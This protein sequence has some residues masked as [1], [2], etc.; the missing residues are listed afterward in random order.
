[1][2]QS[3]LGVAVV[4]TSVLSL[5]MLP[6][7]FARTY[8][9]MGSPLMDRRSTLTGFNPPALLEGDEATRADQD[10]AARAAWAGVQNTKYDAP[11]TVRIEGTDE[12]VIKRIQLA[13]RVS[14]VLVL[15][16]LGT[17]VLVVQ[18]L[19]PSGVFWRA[20]RRLG[21]GVLA[22]AVLSPVLISGLVLG[23]LLPWLG[24]GLAAIMIFVVIVLLIGLLI[25]SWVH[26]DTRLQL[27]VVLVGAYVVIGISVFVLL[28]MTAD[29]VLRNVW[30]VILTAF[31]LL[32]L[33]SLFI[34]GQGLVIEGNQL[35]GWILVLLVVCLILLVISLPGVPRLK[36]NLSR[37]ISNPFLYAGPVGW[38]SGCAP[39]ALEPEATETP[40]A[41]KEVETTEMPAATPSP[42][43]TTM[44]Q[45]PG[46]ATPIAIPLEPYP[47]RQIFP[48]TLFW[49]PDLETTEQGIAEFDIEM[50]DSLTTWRLTALGSTKEGNIGAVSY[51]LRVFQD[52]FIDV[53]VED[54]LHVDEPASFILNV[55]NYLDTPQ[56]VKWTITPSED[57]II[58]TMPEV[59]KV[60]A[61]STTGTILQITPLRTGSII[62]DVEAS[63]DYMVDIIRLELEVTA[64]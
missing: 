33:T 13:R 58:N 53:Q 49:A 41:E 8:F 2:V 28:S 37:T 17:S 39:L 54:I 14:W 56:T 5:E 61:G 46:T 30:V 25:L 4:D 43:P 18:G 19:L 64:D 11:S 34:L 15:L 50:A 45:L 32:L 20:M 60:G 51:D 62:L 47:I 59:V 26:H 9:L 36:S 44:P 55:Y 63:G 40:A 21:W 35:A 6:P 3:V 10:I 23:M 16:P 31:F 7:G 12:S 57:F 48:E 27:A 42:M 52:F 38:L 22:L 29:P 1:M 24:S